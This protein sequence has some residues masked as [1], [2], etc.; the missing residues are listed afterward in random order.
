MKTAE[1]GNKRRH[2]FCGDCGT[3][4]Y[5]CAADNPQSLPTRKYDHAAR[6]LFTAAA[7][8]EAFCAGL[9]GC[10]RPG[11]GN[12]RK[13]DAL[14]AGRSSLY[15]AGPSDRSPN[16]ESAKWFAVFLFEDLGR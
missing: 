2:A 6:G 1:S 9:G 7:D 16:V 12:R 15:Y 5:A 8:L 14:S 3:P 10:P 13:G 4:I 11:A